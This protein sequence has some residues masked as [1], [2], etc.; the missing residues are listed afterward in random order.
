ML[1]V[2]KTYNR[3]RSNSAQVIHARKVALAAHLGIGIYES[4]ERR[5]IR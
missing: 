5:L 1:V 4:I 3:I 2:R